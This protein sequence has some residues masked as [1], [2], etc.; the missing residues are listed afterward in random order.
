MAEILRRHFLQQAGAAA[1]AFAAPQTDPSFELLIAGGRVIDPGRKI[2]A[3]LDIGIA[4]SR[5]AAVGPHLSRERAR[6]VFDAT[7]TMVTPG[8][9][10][11]HGHVFDPFLPVSID[12]DQVGIPKAVTT[13]VDAGSAGANT[14]PGF[15]KYVIERAATRVYALLNISVIGLVV[16]NELYLDPKMIDPR[17]AVKTIQENRGMILGI[18]VRITGRDEDVPH[19]VEVLKKARQAA[20]ETALPIM[21]HWTND[22][23]LLAI[24]KTGD[25][26]VHP[27]NPPRSG[28]NLLGTDGRILPQILELKD[29]G[30]FTDFAHGNHLQWDI[31]EKAAQQGWFPDTISTDI[32]R[33]HAA[34][35]GVVIDLPTTMSK[36]LHLGL[37]PNQAIEKVTANPARILKF[38][39]KPG[40]LEPGAV[41]DV[42]VTEI[43]SGDFD[44]LDSDRQK[45]TVHRRIAPI[46][47]IRAGK[48][49][50]AAP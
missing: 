7:G 17:A 49:T 26:L 23:R 35:N 20:D 43:Q 40:S 21:L 46:A 28:P 14:F 41:A 3:L 37:T 4:G 1:A 29:R 48:L 16:Q 44:L 25:I 33:A 22:F 9:I 30:I 45:R 6:Q 8:L 24:L 13:I 36:F 39:E 42:S 50:L 34:P 2:D 27:F 47:A 38:P 11:M 12:P 18:K 5:I 10:D 32:H 15:R 31:A 19:D